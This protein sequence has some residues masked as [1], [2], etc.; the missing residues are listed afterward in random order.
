MLT[1]QADQPGILSASVAHPFLSTRS[2]SSLNGLHGSRAVL[3]A[4]RLH[5]AA[6]QVVAPRILSGTG[7]EVTRAARNPKR[8]HQAIQLDPGPRQRQQRVPHELT[9]AA[10]RSPRRI[11]VPLP[12]LPLPNREGIPKMH[13]PTL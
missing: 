7:H 6:V 10:R 13:P 4:D 5:R 11:S 9:T 3:L 2:A 12:G 1:A 8:P